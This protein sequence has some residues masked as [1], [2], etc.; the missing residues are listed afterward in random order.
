MTTCAI[1]GHSIGIEKQNS[2]LLISFYIDFMVWFKFCYQKHYER[3]DPR[4]TTLY[5]GI[6]ADSFVPKW[7]FLPISTFKDC[8]L[9]GIFI[10]L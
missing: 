1:V 2:L 9:I 6:L 3:K 5:H 4:D 10:V 7:P 8:I